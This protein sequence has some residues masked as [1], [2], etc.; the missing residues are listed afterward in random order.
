MQAQEERRNTMDLAR[1]WRSSGKK[2][3]TFAAEHGI[4]PW[5]L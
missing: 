2:A 3:R 4:T 5:T 1:Q